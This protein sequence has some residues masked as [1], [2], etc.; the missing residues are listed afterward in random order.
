MNA[1]RYF[2]VLE[3]VC[4]IYG[5]LAIFKGRNCDRSALKSIAF[6]LSVIIERMAFC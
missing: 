5:L 1:D 2:D 6:E 3:D 4:F